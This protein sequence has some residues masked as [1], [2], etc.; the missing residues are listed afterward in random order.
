MLYMLDIIY[1]KLWYQMIVGPDNFPTKQPYNNETIK[2][3]HML[4]VWNIYLHLD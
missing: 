3:N 2:H 4:H 1:L